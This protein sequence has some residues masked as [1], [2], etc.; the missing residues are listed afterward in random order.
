MIGEP[1]VRYWRAW[2]DMPSVPRPRSTWGADHGC[3]A[4]DPYL[5]DV[6]LGRSILALSGDWVDADKL[7][8]ALSLPSYGK[9]LAWSAE[10]WDDPMAHGD[11]CLAVNLVEQA[12]LDVRRAARR[13]AADTDR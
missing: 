1:P 2:R 12:L 13:A 4:L 10:S 5:T 9:R 3:P 6:V 8:H 7:E 11:A